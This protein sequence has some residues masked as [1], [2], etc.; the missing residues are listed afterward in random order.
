MFAARLHDTSLNTFSR[1]EAHDLLPKSN[2]FLRQLFGFI[3]GPNLDERIKW[4]IDDLAEVFRA[5]DVAKI[6]SG[7]GRLTGQQDP[8]L[9]FYETF[10]G[11]YDAKKKK[12]RG[13]WY[14][15]EPVVNFIVRAVDDVLKSEF[16]L[17]DGLADTQQITVDWDTGQSDNKGAVTVRKDMHRVQILDPATGTGT[18]L[19][20]VIKHIAPTIKANAPG[21]WSHYIEQNL[22][23]RLHGFELLMASYAMC[24]MKLDMILTE[25][26]YKPTGAPPRLGV[27]LTNSLEQGDRDVRDLFMAKWLSDEARGAS[28]IKRQT[29]IMCVVGNPP[30]L[31]EGGASTGWMGALMED[32]K[33]EPGGAEKLRERNPKWINDLYVKFLRLSSHLIEKNGEGV[34]GFITNHGYLDNP[35]FRGMR[36]HLLKT[37]DKI[38]VLDLH[39]NAKKKEVAPDGGA[40]KNVFDIMQGVSIIIAVKK[41]G[42][43]Q[44][45]LAQVMQGDLWG[46]RAAKY[47]ALQTGTLAGGLFTKLETPAPQYPLV[48]RNFDAQAVYEAGF[49][50]NA[51]MPANS[52]GIVTARDSLTID[53]D[54]ETLWARVRD[55]ANLPPEEARSKYDLGKDVRDWRVD[56]AQ[57]DVRDHLD[58]TRIVPI[59]YRPFDTR[60]TFY[61]GNS[62]GFICY[63]RDEV[64]R[65]MVYGDNLAFCIPSITKDGLGGIVVDSIAGHKAYSAYDI[66]TIFPLYLYPSEQDLDQSRRVNFDPALFKALQDKAADSEHGTPDEVA[67]FD[68]IY[69]VLHCPAYRQTYA[70]F[71]KIDFPRIPWPASPDAFWDISAKGAQLRAL[72]LM[73]PAAIGATPYPFEG[74]GDSVVEKPRFE[75]GRVWINDSQ[76][77]GN[78]PAVAWEFYIGGYQPAQ[79]WLKD[80]R[81]RALSWDDIRHYQSILKILSETARI[82]ETIDMAL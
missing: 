24:H 4:V 56:W 13:V 32:Y 33:K 48:R 9:H 12:A 40:D 59:A 28:T 65:H 54:K 52:V 46:A 49:A 5:A 25:L 14:T 11:A 37:F 50:I 36:W 69:G 79:K 57:K 51:F 16:N 39:G 7:F 34:L 64:M 26:G 15:P 38:W 75:G 42:K 68:Y 29:P 77:F 23:P 3:A 44:K 58:H 6:M 30:Y 53:I 10:L 82:M 2:P 63:P 61:T 70:E 76:S 22:I 17:R 60:Q 73:Q 66:N 20:E 78:A 80:R 27:Y 18:F 1:V 45:A 81:G 43:G 19:A 41:K 8:F 67:M 71:L 31:G 72:H 62:R 47:A 55:F 35:T 21:N 74:N